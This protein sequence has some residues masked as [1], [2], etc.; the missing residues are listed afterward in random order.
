MVE[1][2]TVSAMRKK[3][4]RVAPVAFERANVKLFREVRSRVPWEP[5]VEG[6]G[7]SF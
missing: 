1:L 5:A 2:K 4:S 7:V 6:S 3:E